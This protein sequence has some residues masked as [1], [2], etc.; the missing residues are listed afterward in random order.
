ML[1]KFLNKK[2]VGILILSLITCSILPTS[3]A[4]SKVLWPSSMSLYNDAIDLD[5]IIPATATSSG[6]KKGLLFTGDP[7]DIFTLGAGHV[8]VNMTFSGRGHQFINFLEKLKKRGIKIT[9]ILCNDNAPV[10]LNLKN[11]PEEFRTPYFYMIDFEAINKDWQKYNFERIVDEYGDIVDSWVIGNEINNQAW[12]FYGASDTITYTKKYCESFKICYEK[13]K[14][15]NE[16]AD[17]YIPF[18]YNWDLPLLRNGDRRQNKELNQYKYNM[19]EMLGL[20]SENLD[21]EIDWGVAL[22]PYPSPVDSSTFFSN[23]YSGYD[24]SSPIDTEQLM[25][26]TLKNFEVFFKYFTDARYLKNDG[27]IRNVIISEFG[28]TSNENERLQAAGI[29]YMW[30]KI[31]D[32]PFIK[33]LLYNAQTDLDSNHFGLVRGNLRKKIS[34][35]V[36]KDMDRPGEYIWCKDLLDEVLDEYGYVDV[37]GRIFNKASESEIKNFL[38]EQQ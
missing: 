1:Y 26:L 11:V 22:H 20:I 4:M 38:A 3:N 35:A 12:N 14:E 28:V 16:N 19:K 7:G 17:V 24:N 34:W 13:I 6:S 27:T 8:A 5:K 37:R 2:I 23:T 10:G 32:N 9:L 30:E 18:D 31:K 33:C 25:L 21:K 36:F 15:K 29:Y